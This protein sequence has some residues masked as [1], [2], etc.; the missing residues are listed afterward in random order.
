MNK[1]EV[2]PEIPHVSQ[3]H[4]EKVVYTGGLQ[5]CSTFCRREAAQVGALQKHTLSPETR[6]PADS[7]LAGVCAERQSGCSGLLLRAE[8]T[9]YQL[10]QT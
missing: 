3:T 10:I 7:P 8:V 1:R 2:G 5:L 6:C 4:S 9:H